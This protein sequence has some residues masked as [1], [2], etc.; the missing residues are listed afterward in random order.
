MTVIKHGGYTKVT[1][2]DIWRVVAKEMNCPLACVNY[3]VALRRIYCQYMLAFEHEMLPHLKEDNL[4]SQFQDEYNEGGGDRYV[5]PSVEKM[6]GIVNPRPTPIHYGIQR[7]A[8]Y[9][10]SSGNRHYQVCRNLCLQLLYCGYLH[11]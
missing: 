9:I 7:S 2:K 11:I 10:G 4:W 8:S 5:P 3:S 6:L 1:D